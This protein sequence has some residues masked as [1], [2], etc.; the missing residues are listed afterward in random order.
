MMECKPCHVDADGTKWWRFL[1]EYDWEG[2]TY[3]F[4]IPARSE[5]EALD[6]LKRL[7]LARFLGQG[8][9]NPVPISKGGFMIPLVV[10]WRNWLWRDARKVVIATKARTEK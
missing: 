1:F 8:D 6:R 9:G 5:E 7:P 4:D 2:K 3:G 10:W